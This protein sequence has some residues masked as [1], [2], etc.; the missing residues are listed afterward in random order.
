MSDSQPKSKPRRRNAASAHSLPT[1]P[2]R[3]NPLPSKRALVRLT[4]SAAPPAKPAGSPLPA[5]PATLLLPARPRQTRPVHNFFI[6]GIEHLF[7]F[8]YSSKSFIPN[9]LS[10]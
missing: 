3:H 5:G 6:S 2:S 7:V 9:I 1:Q 4:G 10:S 8:S